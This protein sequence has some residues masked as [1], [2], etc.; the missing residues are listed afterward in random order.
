[1]AD[2]TAYSSTLEETSQYLMFGRS[3]I[4]PVDLIIGAPATFVR[5]SRLDYSRIT[6]NNLQLACE[7]ARRNLK[8]RAKKQGVANET[9]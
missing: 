9:L 3:A 4:L 6:A 5:Q 1:M 8:E 7:L 2:N